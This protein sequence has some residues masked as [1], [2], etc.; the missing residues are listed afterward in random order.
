MNFLRY[1]LRAGVIWG[2]IW[3]LLLGLVVSLFLPVSWVERGIALGYTTMLALLGV[4][5]AYAR[6]NKPGRSSSV[7]VDRTA[8]LGLAHL[9]PVHLIQEHARFGA[10]TSGPHRWCHFACGIDANGEVWLKVLSRY[11]PNRISRIECADARELRHL[12]EKWGGRCL[13]LG[14]YSDV[15]AKVCFKLDP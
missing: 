8:Q 5:V 4:F 9:P 14:H 2:V 15:V 7:V 11:W 1:A 6:R 10:F 12:F 13:P 3:G